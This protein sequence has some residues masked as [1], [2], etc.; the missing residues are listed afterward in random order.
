[1]SIDTKIG[2]VVTNL[3]RFL[4]LGITRSS[5]KLKTYLYYHTNCGH[6]T[7]QDDHIP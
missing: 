1:M 4:S 6:Q 3:E 2:R 7:M 5:D